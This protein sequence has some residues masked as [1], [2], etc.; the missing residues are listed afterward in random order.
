MK[1]FTV[2]GLSVCLFLLTAGVNAAGGGETSE[3]TVVSSPN[4]KIDMTFSLTENG[5]PQ[6]ELSFDGINIME[7]SALG[8]FE[9][10]D[11][12]SLNRS[13][14]VI[15]MSTETF[16]EEWTPEWGDKSSI[17]NNYEQ[18]TVALQE[19]DEPHRQ[20]N[21]E[22]RIHDDGIGFRYL[23]PE[24][25]NLDGNLEIVSE[26]TEFA[27]SE[28]NTSWW[29]PRDWDNYELEYNE[30]P[31]SEVEDVH[32]PFTMETPDGIHLSVHEAGL[33]DYSS[34]A[35][36]EVEGEENTLEGHLAPWPDSDVKVKKDG[37]PIETPWRTIQVGEDAG[38]LF[39]SDLILNLNEP[40]VIE[41]TSWI[42]PTKY[43][44]VWW[45]MI[46]GLSTWESGD[47]H[48]AT[49]ENAK[50]YIDFASEYLDTENQNI[51]LLVEGWNI[52]WDGEWMENG[53]LFSFTEPYPDYDLEEVINY[54]NENNVEY[55]MHNETSGDIVNYEEQMDE[56]YSMYQDLGIHSIKSG[57]V[58]D[59]GMHNPEDQHH[60]GQYMVNHYLD[61]VQRAADHEIMVNTHEPIK[62]TGL[63][64]TYPNW[65]SREG[66]SGMEYSAFGAE[67]NPPEHDTIIPFTRG[68]AGPI[69]FTPGIFDTE[70]PYNDDGEVDTTR[71]KQLALYVT[72]SSGTQMV[73]DLPDNY[74]DEEGNILP[75][76]QFIRDVP[77]DW[78]DTRVIDSAIGDYTIMTRQSEDEWYLGSITDEEERELEISLDFLDSNQKYMAEIYEDGEG[79]DYEENP[80][81]VSIDRVIVDSE[82]TIMASLAR[83]GGQAVKFSPATEE[84]IEEIPE[85]N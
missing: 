65:V 50:E 3:E 25:E 18:L 10:K 26:D 80:H 42:E 48:G 52:G 79:A 39:E 29:I 60:H 15:D 63:E 66:V 78:D 64:R 7:P 44:G 71:A 58:A 11:Q 14:E 19:T 47:D 84:E 69:D 5:T 9:F 61:A 77:V 4:D 73:A 82:D 54:A 8:G 30:T 70:I 62:G 49:T 76:F 59:E 55:M 46:S 72:I 27:F 22:F 68:L 40:N 17:Q 57:Y 24:Q 45:E 34:M 83:S 32:T 38:D 67:N 12:D 16:E 28:D 1:T 85:Y 21:I 31:L 36:R 74:K 35:L 13:F 2:I 75:E 43:V 20:L 23:I 81:T 37:L 56:A 53:D 41:D 6:Y 51:S 33:I